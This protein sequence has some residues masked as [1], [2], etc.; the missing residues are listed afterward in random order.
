MKHLNQERKS[1]IFVK[2]NLNSNYRK[3]LNQRPEMNKKVHCGL[4][5]NKS[6]ICITD[7]AFPCQR[8]FLICAEFHEHRISSNLSLS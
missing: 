2:D 7:Y 1:I 3:L 4:Q 5:K 6:C 8:Q